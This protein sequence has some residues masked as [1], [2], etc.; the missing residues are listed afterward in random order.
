MQRSTYHL[1]LFQRIF[2]QAAVRVLHVHKQCPDAA[3]TQTPIRRH[4]LEVKR[5]CVDQTQLLVQIQY[6]MFQTFKVVSFFLVRRNSV[7]ANIVR[8][9]EFL[10]IRLTDR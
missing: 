5:S 1:L 4:P 7:S 2:M 6:I 9:G 8:G 10:G 3:R